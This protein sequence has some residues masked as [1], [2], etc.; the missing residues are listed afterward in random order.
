MFPDL[1][2]NFPL[3]LQN[4]GDGSGRL[5]VAE[6]GGVVMVFGGSVGFSEAAVYLDL[7]DKV[8]FNDRFGLMGFCFHPDYASNGHMYVNYN[9]PD[10][11]RTVIARYSVSADDPNR[12]DPLSEYVL[13]EIDQPH[14]FHNGGQLAFGSDG[15]LYIGLG[16][17]GPGGDPNNNG[18]DLTTLHGS[19][20]R[21]DVDRQ[22]DDLPYAIPADNPLV[23]NE[24]GQREEIWAWGFRNPWRFSFDPLTGW[25]WTGDNGEDNYDEIDIVNAGGNYGWRIMEGK[26]CFTPPDDCPT[27]GLTLP[28]WEY[29]GNP[30]RRSV[31]GGYVYR[32]RN[33]PELVG[34]YIYADFLLGRIWSLEYD[35]ELPPLNTELIDGV[36]AISS[37]GLDEEGELYMC[38]LEDG[39][40]YRFPPTATSLAEERAESQGGLELTIKSAN[41]LEGTTAVSYSL[42][43]AAMV[44]VALFDLQGRERLCLLKQRQTVGRHTLRFEIR[45]VRGTRLPA[46]VYFIRVQADT[47]TALL[48]LVLAY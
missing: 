39:H 16:D 38:N 44:S 27:E 17:G 19:F 31:I 20:L 33:N 30:L 22:T 29:G 10:P 42:T 3:D 32:G 23:G 35:G 13:L 26:H 46:G 1:K 41:P 8:L 24:E 25:L 36:N 37:F 2:F 45:D 15:Y 18:Q 43:D 4:A 47:H 5:W 7:T 11:Q 9:A 21:I 34:K 28:V 6:Q 40:I 14:K 48:P 12:A